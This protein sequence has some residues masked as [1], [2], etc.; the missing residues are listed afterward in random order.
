MMSVLRQDLENCEALIH[1]AAVGVSPQKATVDE[2]FRVNV[3]ESLSLWQNALD[4]GIRR[5]VICGSCFEYG[6]AAERYDR[7]PADAPLE[8]V[9]AYGAS[10]A[11]GTMAALALASERKCEVIVLRP[12]TVFGEG[13][14][15]SNFW[16]SL[17]R[18]ALQGEDFSMTA[19]E[20]VRDFVSAEVVA[21]KFIDS[22]AW[23]LSPGGSQVA[24]IGSGEPKSLRQFAEN[25][26][27]QLG[28]TGKLKL[29]A[30]PY[31]QGE[32]MRYVPWL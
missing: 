24:N 23:K 26:W 16:P 31:R 27:A 29:G 30:V 1:F 2:L 15:E 21:Q 20:Q 17:R 9:T 7:V 28:A 3:T 18:A 8:P 13:Q 32:V 14:H 25:W 6:R 12:F 11:A 4:A 19:G 10:K 5:M 22:L